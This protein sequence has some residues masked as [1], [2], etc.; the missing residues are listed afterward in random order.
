MHVETMPGAM[1]DSMRMFQLGILGGKPAPGQ[2]G[3]QPEWAYKGD[4]RCVVEPEHPFA[5]PGFTESFGEEAEIVGV[6]IID[7]GGTPWRVGF[8]LGNDCTDHMLEQRNYLYLAHAKLRACAIGPEL[9]LG[10]LPA[11]VQGEVRIARGDKIIWSS[12][13]ASGEDAMC[14]SVA[15]LEHHLFKYG[16]FRRPGDIHVHFFGADTI[17]ASVGIQVQDGDRFEVEVPL[18]GR[19]LRNRLVVMHDQALVQVRAL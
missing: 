13:F 11:S 19:P 2:I 9:L 10:E 16:L 3:A 12:S 7:A 5:M 1:T 17:S 4:G 8:A 6:Y 15:N 14:H 18:F